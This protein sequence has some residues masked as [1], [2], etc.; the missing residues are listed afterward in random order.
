MRQKSGWK[1]SNAS[2]DR[3]K[4]SEGLSKQK[5]KWAIYSAPLWSE[6]NKFNRVEVIDAPKASRLKGSLKE[7]IVL[8]N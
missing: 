2:I 7:I 8:Q 1:K 3:P 5:S 4:S 6:K